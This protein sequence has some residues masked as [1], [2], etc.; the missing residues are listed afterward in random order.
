MNIK[1]VVSRFLE[2]PVGQRFVEYYHRL[3]GYREYGLHRDDLIGNLAITFKALEYLPKHEQILRE[4]RI[5]VCLDV[6]VKGKIQAP[7][8][9][10]TKPED[11]VA[12]LPEILDW[13]EKR[14]KI[15]AYEKL[16][17]L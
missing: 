7:K 16:N 12:Y 9:L 1:T 3:S 5:S 4:H 14:E 11:D 6:A 8:E 13:L 10:I 2:R 15:R 17:G